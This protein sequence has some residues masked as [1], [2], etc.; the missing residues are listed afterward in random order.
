[1]PI[2]TNLTGRR[3]G[4]LTAQRWV[5][6]NPYRHSLWLCL[7][8]C[9]RETTVSS[10]N[11]SRAKSCGHIRVHHQSETR[12]YT[13]W[14]AMKTRCSPVAND[15]DRRNYFDRGIRVCERWMD[16]RNFLADMGERP[17]GRTIDRID[18]EG[19]YEPGNCRWATASEQQRNKRRK[20]RD[21][22]KRAEGA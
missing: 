13:S 3:F 6:I 19:N 17:D 2:K 10:V 20:Q 22:Q 1:M 12:T 15:R 11:L 16:F 7:C 14:H 5:G 18:N 21:G 4:M 9:G 8:D